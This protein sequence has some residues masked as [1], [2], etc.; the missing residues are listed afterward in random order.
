MIPEI[1]EKGHGKDKTI[2]TGDIYEAVLYRNTVPEISDR[3]AMEIE[4]YLSEMR[5]PTR[6]PADQR[7][8]SMC[9]VLSPSFSSNGETHMSLT[10]GFLAFYYVCQDKRGISLT[11]GDA[12]N[13]LLKPPGSCSNESASLWGNGMKLINCMA[14]SYLM[15]RTLEAQQ[16]AKNGAGHRKCKSFRGIVSGGVGQSSLSENVGDT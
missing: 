10:Q 8:V 12:R 13:D 1:G 15:M 5:L 3:L 7:T 6:I 9:R 11:G 14:S 2:S 16:Q 4:V